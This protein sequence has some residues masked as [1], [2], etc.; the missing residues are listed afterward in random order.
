MTLL[1]ELYIKR[2]GLPSNFVYDRKKK[3]LPNFCNCGNYNHIACIF[4]GRGENLLSGKK[5]QILSYGINQYA[6]IEG[7]DP[8]IHAERDA[9]SNLPPLDRRKSRN[10]Y[11]CNIFVARLTRTNKTGISKP[12]YECVRSMFVL[13][14]LKGYRIK[15]VYYTDKEDNI[16]RERLSH[17]VNEETPYYSRYQRTKSRSSEFSSNNII[18]Q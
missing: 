6:D 3:I 12:C 7:K 18:K 14:E 13:P 2:F 17:L 11:S 9:I 8:S 5:I 4:L 1:D 15:H 16:V 10:L